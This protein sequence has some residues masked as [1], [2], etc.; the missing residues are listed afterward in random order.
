[1]LDRW[2]R[3]TIF[4]V[5]TGESRWWREA[6]HN[7][8]IFDISLANGEKV[9]AWY[10]PQ[11]RPDAPTV[12]YLHGTRWNLNDSA[13]RIERW[14]NMGYAVLAI[15]YRGFGESTPRLPSQ[16][17][18][19]MDA[20]A[21]LQELARRQ[22]S[23]HLRFIYGHSL[24]G[25]VA[26]ALASRADR[27]EFAGLILESTFTSIRDMIDHTRWSQIPGLGMLVTQPFDTLDAIEAIRKPILLLHGTS[28][29]IVPHAMS[30][31]L[32][33]A[34]K[35]AGTSLRLIKIEGAT[36]SGASSRAEYQAAVKEFIED[37]VV[38]AREIH[39]SS[40]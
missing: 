36:H 25:A 30:D 23:P 24:G 19:T 8:E 27:P 11:A 12:L 28:D 9:R 40:N 21:G 33:D 32:L 37:V 5:E 3:K 7:A 31:A 14:A 4:S 17:S 16:S 15:D 13:F 6:P 35:A 34:A 10:V 38:S 18:T 22:P 26:V 39:A 20:R 2:Q 29:A 1:M